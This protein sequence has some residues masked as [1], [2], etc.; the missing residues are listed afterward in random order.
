MNKYRSESG[1]LLIATLF[2][3]R[4]YRT[5]YAIYSL[6]DVDK[7]YN[8]RIYP[9]LYQLYMEMSDVTEYEFANRYF[10]SYQHWDAIC[11]E[12]WFQPYISRWRKEL[13]LKIKSKALLEIIEQAKSTDPKKR[14]E[15]N[16]YLY[17]KVYIGDGSTRGRPS[18]KQ[19]KEEAAKQ[20]KEQKII[21][22]HF[23]L[24]N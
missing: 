16:K 2:L 11:Q 5:E 9:S 14:F 7:E 21:D 18:K 10:E 13:E 8:G 15:A 3:E 1:Q 12:A 20:A 6:S 17:E 23:A 22:E 4:K 19:V 24:L